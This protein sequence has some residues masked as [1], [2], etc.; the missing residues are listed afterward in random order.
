MLYRWV[1]CLSGS[2][3]GGGDDR[4]S[5]GGDGS[6]DDVWWAGNT[7]G[8]AVGTGAVKAVRGVAVSVAWLAVDL[9]PPVLLVQV[10]VL[11]WLC[12]ALYGHRDV[13]LGG[14]TGWHWRRS[15]LLT[16]GDACR[17]WRRKDGRWIQEEKRNREIRGKKR[18][19]N[20]K[21]GKDVLAFLWGLITWAQNKNEPV[22]Q[23]IV[24]SSTENRLKHCPDCWSAYF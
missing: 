17:D 3:G 4:L 21:L 14:C 2:I 11:G 13:G 20:D 1:T 12:A 24:K 19:I 23:N 7:P 22:I 5:R 16:G 6:G 15:S 18:V 9:R 8:Q 10:V